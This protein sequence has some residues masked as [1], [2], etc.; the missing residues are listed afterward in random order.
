[1]ARPVNGKDRLKYWTEDEGLVKVK[2]WLAN[3]L[4]DT[5]IARNIGI[6]TQG[7]RDWRAKYPHFRSV[8][9]VWRK[10]AAVKLEN[11]MVKSAH[12]FYYEEEVVDN[13]GNIVTVKKWQAPNVQAQTFLMKN[14]DHQHYRDRWD[15]EHSG[16][17]PVIIKGEDELTD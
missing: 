4:T 16:H 17:L 3:G 13:K 14:W 9:D 1:M 12:G 11:A 2:E 5:D 6:S 8:F 10:V 7:L 15:V